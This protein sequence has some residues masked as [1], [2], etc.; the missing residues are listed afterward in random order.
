MTNT[1]CLDETHWGTP[2]HYV[3]SFVFICILS[4]NASEAATDRAFDCLHTEHKVNPHE[5]IPLNLKPSGFCTSDGFVIQNV[6][7]LYKIQA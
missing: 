4:T 5:Q 7:R 1:I 2:A 6:L 3:M